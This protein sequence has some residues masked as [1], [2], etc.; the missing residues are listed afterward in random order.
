MKFEFSIALNSDMHIY[1]QLNNTLTNY[2]K[3]DVLTKILVFLLGDWDKNRLLF[4][5]QLHIRIKLIGYSERTVFS[6]VVHIKQMS[7]YSF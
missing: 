4:T 2:T 6:F 7:I 5:K 3:A 1:T